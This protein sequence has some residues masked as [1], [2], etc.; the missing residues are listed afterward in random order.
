MKQTMKLLLFFFLLS[1]LLYGQNLSVSVSQNPVTEGDRF[2]VDFTLDANGT[3]FSPPSFSGFDVLQGPSVSNSTQIING[4]ISQSI[5]WSYIIKA[6]KTGSFFIGPASVNVSGKT[7][8]SDRLKIDVVE[9]SEAE[10]QQRRQEQEA[11]QNIQDQATQLIRENLFVNVKINKNSAFLGEQVIA[12][13]T[14]YH[15]PELNIVDLNY[16]KK[17]IFNGFW[18]QEIDLGKSQK[19][20]T[21]RINGVQ[22]RK[23]D[24]L[25][26]IL[27]PQQTG[28]MNL[29]PM[30]FNS[31]V[32]LQVGGGRRSNSMFDNFFRRNSYRDFEYKVKS[33]SLLVNVKDLPS[34]RPIDFSGAVGDL[35]FES[36]LDKTKTVTGDPITLKVKVSGN[37]NLKLLNAPELNFPTGFEVYEPKLIDNSSVS[38]SGT[39]GNVQFEYLLI[40]RNPGEF[41]IGP[42]ELSYF[43]L[44]SKNYK[45]FKSEEYIVNVGKGNGNIT[46]GT[47]YV[48]KENVEY[49]G[50]D[51]RFIKDEISYSNNNYW[52]MS[53]VHLGSIAGGIGLTILFFIFVKKKEEDE[54]DVQGFKVR[55]A[56]KIAKKR[57]SEA[58]KCLDNNEKEKFYQEVYKAIF[59]YISDKLQIDTSDL[60]K[61]LIK[62]KLETKKIKIETTNKLLKTIDTCEY[63]R[64]APQMGEDNLSKIYDEVSDI[65]SELEDSL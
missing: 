29:E 40:P 3:N 47:N 23:I 5:S 7:V 52:F 10:K 20:E 42:I 64:Y 58:K 50:K 28:K 31:V 12:T 55:K 63:V 65:I 51:I 43:D 1:N 46:N 54:S 8:K 35:K 45:Q 25:K 24:V 38:L 37:G 49:L 15:H 4:N 14:L 39:S 53:Y 61:E 34:P 21:E 36:W 57:L 30:V 32:R 60:N 18:A 16:D 56:N 9:P 26:V 17:P 13:Y 41:K 27:Y 62:Q 2:R 6:K 44:N 19:W 11:E 59:G 48:G 33:K 22:Y